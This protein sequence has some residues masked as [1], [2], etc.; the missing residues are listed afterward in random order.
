MGRKYTLYRID[1]VKL[2]NGK[3][4]YGSKQMT[5][6]YPTYIRYMW[7][8]HGVRITVIKVADTSPTAASASTHMGGWATDERTWSLTAAQQRK[9]IYQSTRL[10]RPTHKRVKSQ[11]FQEHFHGMLDIGSWT[12]CSYQI[13]RT[14][15]GRDGLARNRV[16]LDRA[17]RPKQP[18]PT[19]N[20][21][22]AIMMKELNPPKPIVIN[23]IPRTHTRKPWMWIPENGILSGLTL[24]RI[25]WQLSVVP[26]GKLDH[27]TIRA[28]KVW[29]GNK[30]DGTGI[31]HP[32]HIKQLQGRVGTTKDADWGPVTT[33][34]FQ[35]FLNRNR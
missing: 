12:P 34:A 11:G 4:A 21:G 30:D 13:D 6:W 17:H 24:S 26:T 18:W 33:T 5:A 22:L 10:G 25:Q 16:D 15:G 9:N 14:K 20:V 8:K 23:E 32:V 28:M 2:A 7:E 27:W 29:L 35:R 3:Q 31:L 19:W 1:G